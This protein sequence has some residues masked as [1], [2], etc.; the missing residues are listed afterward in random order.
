MEQLGEYADI[1]AGHVFL[2][3]NDELSCVASRGEL[4]DPAEFQSFVC[5]RLSAD[6]DDETTLQVDLVHARVDRDVVSLRHGSYRLLRLFASNTQVSVPIG[7]L[8]LSEETLFQ[9]PKQ[10][11]QAI[12]D[13]L[14][15]TASARLSLPGPAANDS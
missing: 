11:L 1:R 4:P 14:C 6:L 10:V 15:Q 8:L 3:S 2:W 12:A 7:A 5:E 13:R 9:I